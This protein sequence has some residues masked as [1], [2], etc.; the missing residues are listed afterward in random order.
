MDDLRRLRVK[1]TVHVFR[2][3]CRLYLHTCG[4]ATEIEDPSGF[5]SDVVAKLDGKHTVTDVV[6]RFSVGDDDTVATRIR[7]IIEALD[8]WFFLEDLSLVPPLSLEAYDLDRWSRNLDF[9]GSYCKA[10]DSKY[11]KQLL[12]KNARI[13]LLG[14]GGL[15]S[16]ILYDLIA[17]GFSNIRAVDFDK[18][19]LANLNRQILYSEEDIGRTKTEIAQTR[20][21]KFAPRAKVE[22]MNRRLSSANDVA[23]I[24]EGMDAVICV[25]DKPRFH[26]LNWLNDACVKVGVPFINGGI[27]NQRAVYYTVIPHATGCLEC[28]KSAVGSRDFLSTA[29][30]ED[31]FNRESHDNP[32]PAPAVV[33]LVSTLTGFM[34]SEL[35]RLVT[36]IAPPIATNRLRAVDFTTMQVS[37]AE[38]WERRMEC[39]LCGAAPSHCFVSD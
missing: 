24:V 28:W 33:P 10:H 39:H 30:F 18:I 5:I 19:E 26:I 38:I 6:R 25:A 3:A 8:N 21:L 15:G 9:L 7:I 12:V 37:D 35:I 11:Q 32:Y 20:I 1:P 4:A 16:H 23:S 13:A 31:E 17:F 29:L 27:D 2:T 34:V 14:L 22:F 36:H